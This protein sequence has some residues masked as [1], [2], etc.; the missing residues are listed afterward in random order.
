MSL[1]LLILPLGPLVK[2]S[3]LLLA[4]LFIPSI[5]S[6]HFAASY[7][8]EIPRKALSLLET[9]GENRRLKTIAKDSEVIETQIAALLKENARLAAIA[10]LTNSSKWEGLWARVMARDPLHWQS[11]VFINRGS[12]DGIEVSDAVLAIP[13]GSGLALVGRVMEVGKN[14][15]KV[16]LINDITSAVHCYIEGGLWEGLLEGR[17]T[18]ILK[19]NYIPAYG[20]ISKGDKVFT[21]PSGSVFPA[22]IVIGEISDVFAKKD[23]TTYLSAEVK[24]LVKISALKEVFVISGKNQ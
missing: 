22:D 23:Y 16:L 14:S 1:V 4:Y 24:P 15:A 21:S 11:I 17:N 5:E 18:G 12:S 10:G 19:L 2:T 7:I 20:D 3:R 6:G 9:E 8:G 13:T